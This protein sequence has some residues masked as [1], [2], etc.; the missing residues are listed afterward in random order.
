MASNSE[1]QRHQADWQ[2]FI[3]MTIYTC[4][5][6]IVVVGGMALFLTERTPG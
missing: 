6:V 4:I 5:G 2:N 3:K 1:I